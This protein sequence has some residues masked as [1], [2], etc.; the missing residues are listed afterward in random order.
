M[1]IGTDFMSIYSQD[2]ERYSADSFI[3]RFDEVNFMNDN[4]KLLVEEAEKTGCKVEL[5]PFLKDYTTFRIGGEAAALFELD[6]VQ[7]CQRLIPFAAKNN[8]PYFILGKGSNILA[9]DKGTN[10]VIFR[11]NGS[12]PELIGENTIRCFAGVPLVKL[13]GFALEN[14]LGGLEFAYGI[15]GSVGG[16]VYMNA[17]A[18][19]GEM[20]D[21][22]SSVTAL[23]RDGNVREYSAEELELSY[24]HSRFTRSGEVILSADIKLAKGDKDCIKARMNELMEKRRAKQPLE[25]PSAGSTFKRPQGA[26]AAQ[27]IEECGL[28]GLSVGNAQVSEKHSG[29]V[30]NRGG[31]SFDDVMSVIAMVKQTVEEKT[32]YKLECEPIIISDRE[33]YKK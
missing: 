4:L 1:P 12:E 22:I 20:K 3:Q 27:L 19:G 6:S 26:F 18:Y 7:K 31:A 30:I 29:F 11:I 16:A 13:C 8:I 9:D 2:T 23:D 14:E 10:A 17:G 28:K 24:R 5:K 21:V 32:G 15:P 33:E 25:F